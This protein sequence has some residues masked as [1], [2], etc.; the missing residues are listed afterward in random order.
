MSAAV[1]ADQV[2]ERVLKMC[3]SIDQEFQMAVGPFG[4]F[5]AQE[6]REQWLALGKKVNGTHAAQYLQMLADQIP[7]APRRTVFI[8]QAMRHIR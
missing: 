2:P 6:V 5:V 7:N 3:Q 8:S 1:V 4:S